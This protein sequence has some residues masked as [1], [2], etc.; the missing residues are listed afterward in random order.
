MMQDGVGK[1]VAELIDSTMEYLGTIRK[2]GR[3][4]YENQALLYC[5]CSF[6]CSKTSS[7]SCG[8]YVFHMG[9][10]RPAIVGCTA[11]IWKTRFCLQHND[12]N[13]KALG[14]KGRSISSSTSIKP[15]KLSQGV[16][17]LLRDSSHLIYRKIP[18][19]YY[20]SKVSIV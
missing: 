3:R 7:H 13:M 1:P 19:I 18:L 4:S 17:Q 2:T 8:L 14:E 12:I 6:A 20:N 16:N 10:V 11:P 15:R 5:F 9:A